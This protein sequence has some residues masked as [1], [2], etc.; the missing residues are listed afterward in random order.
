MS[1]LTAD[2]E[3]EIPEGWP[4]SGTENK[5]MPPSS[6]EPAESSPRSSPRGG[7]KVVRVPGF[8]ELTI[9]DTR[10]HRQFRVSAILFLDEPIDDRN[11]ATIIVGGNAWEVQE[12]YAKV[13]A[14]MAESIDSQNGKEGWQ[15]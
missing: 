11:G 12:S 10:R 15:R 14:M 1:A 8:I 5:T 4:P 7:A 6:D 13:A 3:D 2:S 9:H